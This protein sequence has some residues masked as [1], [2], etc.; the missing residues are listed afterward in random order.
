M[1]LLE[2]NPSSSD[3]VAPGEELTKGSSHVIWATIVAVILVSAAI[4]AYFI[5]GEKPP[6]AAGEVT[7]IVVHNMHTETSGID[8][9][10]APMPKEQFD[11]VFIFTHVNLHNQ[12]KN[13]L[14]LRQIMT[15][16]TLDDGIH[17]SYAATP[18]DY[19]RLFNAYP[20]LANL[21]GTTLKTDETI[22]A[23]QSLE[24]DFV[25]AFHMTRAQFDARKGLDFSVS[26]RYLPDLKIVPNV[27]V[28]EQ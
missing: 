11:Q 8:A 6:A 4:A 13:P 25:S 1:S 20:A 9:A 18:T 15:N 5:A 27:T 3:R 21:R 14:F 17:T 2:Q 24:G 28:T 19:N 12:S 16:V 22:P 23:G 26:F 10:G 7:A